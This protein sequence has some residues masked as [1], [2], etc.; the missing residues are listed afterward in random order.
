MAKLFNRAKMTTSTTGSG[1]VTL[2][3]AANGFQSFA[4]AGVSDGDVIQYVIEEGSAWE[5][6]TGAYSATGTSLTRTPS[7]SSSGGAA[8]S[9][10]GTARVSITAVA[11]QIGGGD[12]NLSFDDNAK[13]I[14]GAGSDL[15]LYHTGSQSVIYDAGTGQLNITTNGS[16]ILLEKEGGDDLARFITDDAVELFYAGAKKFSTTST[17][18]DVTGSVTADGL[19]VENTSGYGSLEVGGS[20]GGLLDF[21]A[22][23]SDDF[24]SR[25][26]ANGT[27]FTLD[28]QNAGSII[29]NNN[30]AERMRITSSGSVGIGT[31]SPSANLHVNGN[32]I[33][34]T[35][36]DT[37]NTGTVTLD[38]GANQN[39][40]LTLT[41][42]VTLAN[43]TTEQVGQSGF[44]VFIQ[45][46]T[47]GRTV[48]L[49]TDYETAGGA[50]LTLSSA[51][52]T[53]DVVPYIVAAS[54]RILLGAPQLAFA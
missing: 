11:S 20:S 2:S 25:I 28:N 29:F 17:G 19:N 33:A 26:I 42:N 37:T 34:K 53:T 6:G 30:A 39:F 16:Q 43:P 50:G 13:A 14:F 52:S 46:S 44:I 1:T 9:L 4:D 22:P 8:I 12:R 21:K 27:D 41:G 23:F 51:A 24:D 54:G 49:G 40:V 38:F 31:S 48:S 18:V 35:D 7:E 36:T 47:G 5:I 15:Q 32:A 3:A 10:G 45:D